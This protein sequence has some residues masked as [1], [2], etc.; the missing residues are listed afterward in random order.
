MTS[1][2]AHHRFITQTS[3]LQEQG[4]PEKT[5]QTYTSETLS[6]IGDLLN[7]IYED[8]YE[9]KPRSLSFPRSIKPNFAIYLEEEEV[10][11]AQIMAA[12]ETRPAMIQIHSNSLDKVQHCNNTHREM[13]LPHLCSCGC[14]QPLI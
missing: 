1:S 14:V 11:E 13:H 12:R 10:E 6:D 8:S 9:L 7:N 4:N 3:S 5:P 2:L